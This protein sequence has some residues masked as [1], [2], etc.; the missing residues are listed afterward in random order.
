MNDFYYG[1][2]PEIEKKKIKKLKWYLAFGKMNGR[3]I[4]FL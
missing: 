2:N 4:F 1:D 3:V